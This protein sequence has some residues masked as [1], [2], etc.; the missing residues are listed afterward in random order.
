MLQTVLTD[1]CQPQIGSYTISSEAY[2]EFLHTDPDSITLSSRKKKGGGSKWEKAEI[3]HSSP[4]WGRGG[5][6]RKEKKHLRRFQNLLRAAK[7]P[8]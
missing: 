4:Y 5:G 2:F 7:E 1:P 6:E 8:L 3:V